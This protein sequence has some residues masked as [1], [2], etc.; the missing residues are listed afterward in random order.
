MVDSGSYL[1]TLV[2]TN[3]VP[4]LFVFR[5]PCRI[6]KLKKKRLWAGFSFFPILKI[7][8]RYVWFD[9]SGSHTHA[10]HRGYQPVVPVALLSS[11]LPYFPP[12]LRTGHE[13]ISLLSVL[14][15]VLTDSGQLRL[16]Y[17]LEACSRT[18]ADF[19]LHFCF[20]LAYVAR[21]QTWDNFSLAPHDICWLVKNT[22]A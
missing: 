10:L 14:H 19:L 5:R 2:T 16:G 22:H 8:K 1:H 4:V 15:P 7:R 18:G 20:S 12:Y 9:S 21:E 13:C 17:F 11:L 3:D 6:V